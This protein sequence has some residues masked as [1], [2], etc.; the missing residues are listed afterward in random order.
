MEKGYHAV[1]LE[2]NEELGINL[3][4]QIPNDLLEAK[5]NFFEYVGYSIS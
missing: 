3:D 2:L 5:E 1:K 4:T